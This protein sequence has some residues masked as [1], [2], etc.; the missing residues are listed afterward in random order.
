[1]IKYNI[2]DAYRD[3]FSDE[4]LYKSKRA[5]VIAED[6]I[7]N[8]SD[9]KFDV[10]K[11]AIKIPIILNEMKGSL[12][13]VDCINQIMKEITN[14]IENKKKIYNEITKTVNSFIESQKNTSK[15]NDILNIYYDISKY[16]EHDIRNLLSTKRNKHNNING[17][18][19]IRLIDIYCLCNAFNINPDKLILG[20][21][22]HLSKL[23]TNTIFSLKSI[24]NLLK[25]ISTDYY[26]NDRSVNEMVFDI[27]F[28]IFENTIIDKTIKPE[29]ENKIEFQE[30]F[31]LINENNGSDFKNIYNK[32]VVKKALNQINYHL[33]HLYKEEKY[34]LG[35]TRIKKVKIQH[36]VS[37]VKNFNLK[38]IT[39][40]NKLYNYKNEN[41]YDF[42]KKKYTNITNK[43]FSEALGIS[44]TSLSNLL[45]CC[46]KDKN[47]DKKYEIISNPDL[48]T[49]YNI[50]TN[51]D[52][53]MTELI[54]QKRVS[55]AKGNNKNTFTYL[56]DK[57]QYKI[58][59]ESFFYFND[60]TLTHENILK[61]NKFIEHEHFLKLCELLKYHLILNQDYVTHLHENKFIKKDKNRN[62][63]IDD[64][65]FLDAIYLVCDNF[66]SFSEAENSRA[67]IKE[68]T[69]ICFELILNNIL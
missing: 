19:K 33:S 68:L 43:V 25:F 18:R 53:S 52:I 27:I 21:E 30:L 44:A 16:E 28:S 3:D 60:K 7:Y 48:Q 54:F 50:A 47:N 55:H 6:S 61:V 38:K 20:Y 39:I 58:F 64:G 62:I 31:N 17:K 35:T 15:N 63:I 5:R 51:F 59:Y 49:L 23:Y 32:I 66:L 13:E 9:D 24:H 67:L 42:K 29:Q 37:N 57:N 14:K 2:F 34:I 4:L 36:N 11:M 41:T 10:T 46:K 45:H 40:S 8:Y 1:M 22:P 56:E 26:I 65:D 69:L 12:I